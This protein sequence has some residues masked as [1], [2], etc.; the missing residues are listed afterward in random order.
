MRENEQDDLRLVE[1]S[2]AYRGVAQLANLV[3]IAVA[4][5]FL[6]SSA[7]AQYGYGS[8]CED[9]RDS[10]QSAASDLA[11]YSRRLQRCAESED[12]TDDCSAEFYRVNSAYQD[13]ES[14]VSDVSSYCD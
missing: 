2:L 1:H 5:L 9:A 8:D 13:Y 12:F 11:S 10:A 3:A 7:T 4:F 14:A 6:S